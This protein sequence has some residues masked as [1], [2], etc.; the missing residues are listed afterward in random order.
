M[1]LSAIRA[2]RRPTLVFVISSLWVICC[3]C[4]DECGSF[5]GAQ[6]M[7]DGSTVICEACRDPFTAKVVRVRSDGSE[8]WSYRYPDSDLDFPHTALWNP[9]DTV[10]IADTGHGRIILVDTATK[11]TIWSSEEITFSDPRITYSYPN[12]ACLLPSGRI[13]TSIR[14]GHIVLEFELDGTIVWSF[15]EWDVPGNDNTHL[16]GPHWP[17]RKANG[18]TL[19]PDSWN[20]R[21]IEVTPAG[22]IVWEYAPTEQPYFLEWP[23][24]AQD[25]PNG[26]ILITDARDYWEVSRQGVAVKHFLRPGMTTDWGYMANLLQ[27]GNYLLCGWHRIDEVT[28]QGDIVWTRCSPWGFSPEPVLIE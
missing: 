12:H 11:E 27:N 15:G 20:H 26:N 25:L 10:L 2:G 24:C 6:R 7:E 9:D 19:I 18:N 5:L 23:R 22:R 16:N 17:K 8:I 21:I 4:S 3:A 14:D 28:P 1:E 13:L